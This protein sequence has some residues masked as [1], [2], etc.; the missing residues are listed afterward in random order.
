LVA[1]LPLLKLLD[2]YLPLPKAVAARESLLSRAPVRTLL[3]P[4]VPGLPS[5]H[6]LVAS[7]LRLQGFV[8]ATSRRYVW[9]THRL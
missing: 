5:V 2:Q 3:E 7:L 8:L 6:L 9:F 1:R 4:P